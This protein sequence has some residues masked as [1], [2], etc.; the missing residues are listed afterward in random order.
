MSLRFIKGVGPKRAEAFNRIGINNSSDL[1]R[2]FPFRY[3]DRRN[4][5]KIAEIDSSDAVLIKG[6]V[7]AVN[8]KRIPYF[9]ARRVKSIF[10][11][12]LND[13]TQT[14]HC[15]WFNQHYLAG[16]IRKNDE[17]VIYGKPAREGLIV[18]FNSPQ[19]EKAGKDSSLDIGR[20]VGIYHSTRG[21]T[22]KFLR[23]IFFDVFN[24][25]K[26]QVIDCIPLYIREKETMPDV[27][28]SIHD[29][30]F[31][32]NMEDIDAARRRF[33]F[34]ELFFSQIMVYLRKARHKQEATISLKTD[35]RF[36]ERFKANLGFFLT[37]EQDAAINDI[38]TDVGQAYPMHRLLQGDVGCGKTVVAAVGLGL[39]VHNGF[40]GALMVPTEVL[41]YQH[42][43]SLEKIFKGFGFKIELLVSSSPKEKISQIYKG[44]VDG[45]I[46]IIVGTHAL[47]QDQVIFKD[48]A[49]TVIDEQHKFG[50]G[51]RAL[52]PKKGKPS[53]HCLVMSATPIPRSL[54]LSMY[55]D[56][57]LTVIKMLP[58]GRKSC[59][60]R[61]VD[62]TKRSEVYEFL[63]GKLKEGRQI[64]IVYPA[65][66][67]SDDS[68]IEALELA[69]DKLE[70]EF[71]S[72]RIGM[73]HGQMK[74]EAKN[75][76]VDDFRNNKI[77]I[78]MCTTVVEVG[79]SVDNA[80]VMVVENPE[81]FG[82]AQLHQLRGRVK[83]SDYQPHFI[84]ISKANISDKAAE[85]LKA[86]TK[87]DDGFLIAENDLIL[88]GPG[89]FFG[90]DQHGLP[91]LQIANP[92]RDLEALK[93]ARGWAHDI[94]GDDA[95]LQK[96]EHK[97]IKDY[98]MDWFG[99]LQG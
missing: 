12:V 84:L 33:I 52:L 67:E 20:I 19:Y 99:V 90:S 75:K 65:I 48:L 27:V 45:N 21:L 94:V 76:V 43:E 39:A 70:K 17:I 37:S 41:A 58:Q 79:V 85:R 23:K 16:Y 49:F 91:M 26:D 5:K 53:P 98:L 40:Q 87:T 18:K 9:R 74:N 64:Y 80:T 73:F 95:N 30:H 6:K 50:V 69:F 81:R 13:G 38:L 68:E 55:G 72:Y 36:V 1:L 54:A 59:D 97:V 4:F 89:D 63:Q 10:E 3:E 88:R 24:S 86:I 92:L 77:N 14:A 15:T 31:P 82:L 83:R 25:E 62:E 46:D 96:Y 93:K 2:Y 8:L 66:E 44:L 28:K 47:I 61:W 60:N 56:L 35:A 22:Q 7:S 11:V 42:K 57:D 29:I 78:L 71:K 51:Q 32:A 34:E